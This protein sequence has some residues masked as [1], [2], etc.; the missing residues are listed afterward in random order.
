[1]RRIFDLGLYI[2]RRKLSQLNNF[3]AGLKIERGEVFFADGYENRDERERERR[4]MKGEKAVL[5]SFLTRCFSFLLFF[6]RSRFTDFREDIPI[7][8]TEKILQND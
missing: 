8:F 4:T 5:V 6:S 2:A 7:R 3:A 1:M